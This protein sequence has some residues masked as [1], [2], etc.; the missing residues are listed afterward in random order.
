M[1]PLSHSLFFS[2]SF[3]P[4]FPSSFSSNSSSFLSYLNLTFGCFFFFS[5]FILAFYSCF[6]FSLL[7]CLFFLLFP[8]LFYFISFAS[9]FSF[10]SSSSFSLYLIL[11]SACDPVPWHFAVIWLPSSFSPSFL[12]SLPSPLLSPASPL[13]LH[14]LF[15][16]SRSKLT[17]KTSFLSL[18][19]AL[20]VF[21]FFNWLL[22]FFS[23]SSSFLTS[24]FSP[25]HFVRRIHK[26]SLLSLCCFIR[27]HAPRCC[28]FFLFL[29]GI[30]VEQEN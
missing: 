24:S 16:I 12:Y 18:P 1:P 30:I 26:L 28:S 6:I 29:F 11:R 14:H 5:S 23:S 20:C 3:H 10:P 19:L 4:S 22:H 21:P 13:F 15:F 9:Y 2:S 8:F 7:L 25:S 27:P 17:D